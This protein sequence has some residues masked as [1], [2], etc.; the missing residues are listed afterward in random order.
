MPGMIE[1]RIRLLYQESIT[2]I[3][4]DAGKK[5]PES[6]IPLLQRRAFVLSLQHNKLLTQSKV[7]SGKI[8]GD[9]Q[10]AQKAKGVFVD[11]F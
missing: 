8:R 5:H 9:I 11:D 6:P 7:F 2:P 10:F 4:P 3:R 1:G